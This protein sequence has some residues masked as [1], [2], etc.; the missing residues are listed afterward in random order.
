MNRRLLAA[1][2][3]AAIMGAW[4]VFNEF[5]HVMFV[6]CFTW[7][8]VMGSMFDFRVFDYFEIAVVGI[9]ILACVAAALILLLGF[10][11]NEKK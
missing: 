2:A 11:S 10:T 6:Y 3:A 8:S 4:G 9:G 1:L 7:T 5:L